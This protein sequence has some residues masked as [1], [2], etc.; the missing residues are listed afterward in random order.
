[1]TDTERQALD[2]LAEL[3]AQTGEIE[4][5][6]R[7]VLVACRNFLGY[8][9]M[10]LHDSTF[11]DVQWFVR[12]TDYELDELAKATGTSAWADDFRAIQAR[13]VAAYQRVS[14]I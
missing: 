11:D 10:S 14:R 7:V 6:H 8:L 13:C 9:A 4:E 12:D 2:R 3:S 5:Q 1:M